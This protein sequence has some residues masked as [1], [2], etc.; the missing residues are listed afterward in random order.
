MLGSWFPGVSRPAFPTLA[1][2]EVFMLW[3][4]GAGTCLLS[5]SVTR[6]IQTFASQNEVSSSLQWTCVWSKVVWNLTWILLYHSV[7]VGFYLTHAF[8][9]KPFPPSLR[10]RGVP[11]RVTL[12]KKNSAWKNMSAKGK[13]S[14]K[15]IFSC[16]S[17]HQG[18][19]I[20]PSWPLPKGAL[21][22]MFGR[23]E[24]G[25]MQMQPFR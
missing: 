24:K 3:S 10:T 4:W 1:V 12:H 7:T 16:L 13:I 17:K 6:W 19:L 20:V 8:S 21:S 5:V 18:P 9:S 14:V 22:L 23:F 15:E 2:N 11:Q 25:G